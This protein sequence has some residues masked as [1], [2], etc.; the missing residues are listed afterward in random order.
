MWMV[1]LLGQ[2]SCPSLRMT[3]RELILRRFWRTS[4][5]RLARLNIE[6]TNVIDYQLEARVVFVFWLRVLLCCLSLNVKLNPLCHE[7]ERAYTEDVSTGDLLLNVTIVNPGLREIALGGL[8]LSLATDQIF[9]HRDLAAVA[10][11]CSFADPYVGASA[12]Y[13]Q[14]VSTTGN[15]PVL[16]LTID[17]EASSPCPSSGSKP[18]DGDKM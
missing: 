11:D 4:P 16:L 14:M 18:G 17:A 1:E 3:F 10:R 6:W 12:G 2:L 13:V 5:C 8:G 15:G 9:S 7:V